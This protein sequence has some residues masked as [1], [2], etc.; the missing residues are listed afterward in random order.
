MRATRAYVASLGTTGVLVATSLVLLLVVSALVA[1]DGW[2]GHDVSDDVDEMSVAQA[3]PRVQVGPEQ[4]AADAAPAAAAVSDAPAGAPADGDDA[5]AGDDAPDGDGGG[6]GGTAPDQNA[7]GGG[8]AQPA[9]PAD[10]PDSVT[11]DPG[12]VQDGLSGTTR[13]VTGNVG[14][15]L[16]SVAPGSGTTVTETGEALSEIVESLPDVPAPTVE[17]KTGL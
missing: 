13:E 8:T 15:T 7:G 1:F 12:Q 6:V 11:V 10:V 2:S 14:Q 17:V 5:P 9:V 16:D 3:E 4:V